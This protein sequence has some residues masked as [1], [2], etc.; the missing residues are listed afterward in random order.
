V[1]FEKSFKEKIIEESRKRY[2]RTRKEV[3]EK[4]LINKNQL[5]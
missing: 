2:G 4:N 5:F 3:G 1:Q